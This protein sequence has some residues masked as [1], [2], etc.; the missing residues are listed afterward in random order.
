M[1]HRTGRLAELFWGS[2]TIKMFD[3]YRSEDFFLHRKRSFF[4]LSFDFA[5]FFFCGTNRVGNGYESMGL[6]AA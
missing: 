2:G 1:S 6:A 5:S 4:Y 3:E